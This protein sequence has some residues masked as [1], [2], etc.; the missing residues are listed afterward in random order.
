MNFQMASSDDKNELQVVL[1]AK[2]KAFL[3]LQL[4]YQQL[5]E[6]PANQRTEEEKKEVNR[7]RRPYSE[8]KAYF[9]HLVE[10]R[11]WS[12][13][14]G[15]ERV[16]KHRQ[17]RSDKAKEDALV[18]DRKRKA[19]P[20]ARAADKDRKAAIRNMPMPSSAEIEKQIEDAMEPGTWNWYGNWDW[21]HKLPNGIW[22]MKVG[23]DG[24]RPR[25][26]PQDVA[27]H[28]QKNHKD[29]IYYPPDEEIR[30]W[31]KEEYKQYKRLR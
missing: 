28:I 16:E 15:A 4:R 6:I 27:E 5:L 26:P 13:A 17:E 12:P 19:T 25:F 8:K 20:A 10:K 22:R 1:S 14:S 7:L 11:K 24:K 2:E 29:F 3:E 30:H 9:P 23:E 18:A 21:S 31:E